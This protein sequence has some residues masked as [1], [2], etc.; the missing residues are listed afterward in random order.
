MLVIANYVFGWNIQEYEVVK[1]TTDTWV[2]DWDASEVRDIVLEYNNLDN[3]LFEFIDAIIE[4][5]SRD[6]E[7]ILGHSLP[8]SHCDDI[9]CRLIHEDPSINE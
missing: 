2:L 5:R 8:T 9:T 6:L 4:V 7:K 1:Q 3:I